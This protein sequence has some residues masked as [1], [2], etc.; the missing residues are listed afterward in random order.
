[1]W[2]TCSAKGGRQVTW[3][4]G[5]RA[6]SRSGRQ[7]QVSQHTPPSATSSQHSAHLKAALMPAWQPRTVARKGCRCCRPAA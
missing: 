6:A 3:V 7:I 2:S 1:M 4:V 5:R